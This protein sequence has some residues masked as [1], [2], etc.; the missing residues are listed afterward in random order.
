MAIVDFTETLILLYIDSE[1]KEYVQA[2]VLFRIVKYRRVKR[3]GTNCSE[4]VKK[5]KK[6]KMIKYQTFK[7]RTS[8]T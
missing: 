2:F 5:A 6:G 4:I 3:S 8:L 1:I 7:P